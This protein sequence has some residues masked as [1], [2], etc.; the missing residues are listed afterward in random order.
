[1]LQQPHVTRHR[2]QR[3]L[4]V[5]RRHV[6]KLLQVQVRALQVFRRAEQRRLGDLAG[7]QFLFAVARWR[8]SNSRVRC[9]TMLFEMIP[10]LGQLGL[11]LEPAHGFADQRR[12]GFDEL[13]QGRR[14]LANPPIGQV[15]GAED[16][17]PVTDGHDGHRGEA[18][19][20]A[21][22]LIPRPLGAGIARRR[23]GLVAAIRAAGRHAGCGP[24]ARRLR[25]GAQAAA[26][27]A[28]EP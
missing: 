22:A 19:L 21:G 24:R 10:M 15:D 4:Q 14:E 23:R 25:D 8:A 20:N 1:M 11:R 9:L 16:A 3:L 2:S 17:L 28:L 26:V 27:V 6:A 5:V 7:E 13:D 18:E 12:Q